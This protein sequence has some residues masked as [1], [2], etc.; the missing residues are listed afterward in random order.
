MDYDEVLEW[1]FGL[2]ARGIKFGL[3]NTRELLRRMGD[4]HLSFNSIHVGGTNGKGS[5]C[6]MISSVL[7]ECGYRTGLYTS[8]H[9]RDFSERIKVD[10][11]PIPREEVI[12]LAGVLRDHAEQMER[13][14][15]RLTFFE[16]TTV[17]AFC[18]FQERGVEEAV[19][20]VGMGGRLDATNVLLPRCS[21]ITRIGV[22]HV[23][24]LGSDIEQIAGEKAGIIK[25]GVPV[26]TGAR[27]EVEVIRRRAAELGAPLEA[28]GDPEVLSSDLSGLVFRVEGKRLELPLI[29]T[30]QSEN[31]A[32]AYRC[33]MR[34]R[35]QG[36]RIEERCLDRGFANTSWPGRMEVLGTDP[37]VILDVTHTADGAVRV[38]RDLEE[39]FGGYI[40]VLGVLNDKDLEGM[41]APLGR[42]CRVAIATEPRSKRAFPAERVAEALRSHCPR[43]EV[44]TG[45]G[46]A[47]ERALSL[48]APGEVV[49][50]TGSLYTG[51]EA[52]R[53]WDERRGENTG[54]D[55]GG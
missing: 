5:V 4:P 53:W 13:E 50:V 30:Y 2:E 52:R 49:L 22:E 44:A 19:V 51:G 27:E 8:P 16:L 26:I 45:V 28:V 15:N 36:M 40:L 25:P 17:M 14:G 37:M 20:E 31:G 54:A 42:L 24:W 3:S 29:G 41:A 32:I 38:A 35:G 7:R 11:R 12:R 55:R 48:A 9:I 47:C 34:L 43:V 23:E 21:V 10:G 18:H 39:L 6:A 46:E 33:L 1:L